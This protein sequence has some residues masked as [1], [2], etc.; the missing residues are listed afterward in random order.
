MTELMNCLINRLV[1]ILVVVLATAQQPAFAQR[2]VL[3]FSKWSAN[4][5][6]PDPV[7]ISF[8]PQGRAFVTQTQRRKANDLD[9][10]ANLDWVVND[11]S[12]Q[13][14]EQKRDF[15]H[16]RLAPGKNNSKRVADLNGDGSSDYKDLM[17]ISE[18]IHVLEDTDGDGTADSTKLFADG[19]NTEVT[20]IA[21]GVL[22]HQGHVYATIAPDVW[23]LTDTDGDGTADAR[24]IIATGFGLHIAYAGHD[25]HGLTVGPDGKIYWSIGDKGINSTSA[26]GRTF[27]YPNQGG[28]MRC[29]PDGSDFEVFA[30]GLR[31]VQ[32]LAF[33]QYGNLFGVDNDSDKPGERERFVY[34]VKNMDAG[35]RCNY[36][37]R[38]DNYNPWMDEQLWQTHRDGQA[39]YIIPPICYSI[40]GPA[41]FAFNPGT[42]LGPE[43]Y[44]YFFL[45]GAPG[46]QQIAFQMQPD[47]ASFQ[48]I[49]EHS[50]GNG[51]PIVGIN[52]GPDGGLYGVDWGG[53]YPLNQTGAVWKID[54]PQHVDSP[55]RKAVKDLLATGMESKNVNELPELLSH[56]D[57]RVRLNAQFELVKRDEGE[58]LKSLAENASTPLL[59]RIHAM[60]GLGQLNAGGSPANVRQNDDSQFRLLCTNLLSDG[61]PEVQFQA[62]RLMAEAGISTPALVT[63]LDSPN[64]RVRFQ[65][66][67]ALKDEPVVGKLGAVAESLQPSQTYLRHAVCEAMASCATAAELALLQQNSSQMTRLCAVVAL[68]R[69]DAPEVAVFLADTHTTVAEEAARAIHDDFSIVPSLPMLAAAI[70][71]VPNSVARSEAFLRRSINANYRLGGPKQFGRLITFASNP[72][73]P[74]AMRIEALN[75]LTTWRKPVPLDRVTGRFRTYSERQ[76][77]LATPATASLLAGMLL[78]TNSG[79]QAEA[80]KIHQEFQLLVEDSLLSQL[81]GSSTTDASLI[82]ES[83]NLLAAQQST[84]LPDT[85]TATIGHSDDSVRMRSLEL[86]VSSRLPAACDV[87]LN[88]YPTANSQLR[89]KIVKLMAE[90]G[91]SAAD[92]FLLDKSP[93][94]L[95]QLG[96]SKVAIEIMDVLKQRSDSDPK[97]ADR[98]SLLN[99]ALEEAASKSPDLAFTMCLTGGDKKTGKTIF[100]THLQAQCVRCHRVGDTGSTVGPNLLGIA[101]KRDAAYLLRAI[102]TPSADIEPNYRSVVVVLASGKSLPGIKVRETDDELVIADSQGKE[103]TI[104]KDDIDDVAEQ[105]VSI[106]PE[107]SKTLSLAE[108][109]DVLAYLMSLNK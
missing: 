43:Y 74:A 34:I 12:F 18:L 52:F 65:A 44:N 22:H 9:I 33:D 46:G 20:G 48:M 37:Y 102:V 28:V 82:L 27:L 107:I 58:R 60:W 35:W 5:N 93:K 26:E 57:Q 56:A 61:D 89:Q 19:F 53:G 6:V 96:A 81:A 97:F 4:I 25:M 90:L 8:D 24:Q 64:D 85:L 94:T 62:A 54:D 63:L 40:N 47:G 73:M 17:F 88:M 83:L 45:T 39:A 100:N 95:E 14:V 21:A 92:D 106:M 70:D 103:I 99:S 3:E 15:Y 38:G 41:G 2:P 50:I 77:D 32:E 104:A 31:N 105:N 78:D 59:G 51:L 84:L 16:Q 76:D 79:I 1:P 72:E 71:K 42:A 86:M 13:S 7:A 109:R 49:N 87:M 98:Q 91:T 11:V 80:M 66:L 10:R 69:Q 30:H 108:I 75:A 55:I 29:N 68:R 23:K 36:Q 101:K 67:M